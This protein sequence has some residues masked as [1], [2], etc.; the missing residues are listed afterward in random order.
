LIPWGLREQGLMCGI[1]AVSYLIAMHSSDT[2][3]TIENLPYGSLGLGISI[4]VSLIGVF[5]QQAQRK[6]LAEQKAALQQQMQESEALQE[7]SRA[8]TSALSRSQLLAP[9][10]MAVQRLCQCH[11]LV[12][13][14]L[15]QERQD[16]DLW[17]QTDL[18]LHDQRL[19]LEPLLMKEILQVG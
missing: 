3:Y 14:M 13:G 8:L 9:L 10:T 6:R 1:A 4:G 12:V 2:I 5:W 17:T 16:I 18:P 15:A 11:G 19:A 7:F